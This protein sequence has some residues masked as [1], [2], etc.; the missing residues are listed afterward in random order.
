MLENNEVYFLTTLCKTH[1]FDTDFNAYHINFEMD[2]TLQ[3]F[4]NY[5]N[6]GHYKPFSTW[7]D[8]TSDHSYISL[9]H[10]LL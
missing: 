6:L 4:I 7:S 10:I 3:R 5:R 9:L 2:E 1:I 8:P